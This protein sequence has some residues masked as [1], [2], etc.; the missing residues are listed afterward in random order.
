MKAQSLRREMI[1]DHGHGEVGAVLAAIFLR[2]GKTQMPRLVGTLAHL[3]KQFLP[4]MARQALI[5]PVGAGMFAAMI[6]ETLIVVLRLKRLDFLLDEIVQ[7]G[8]IVGDLLG[9]PEIHEMPPSLPPV[10][11]FAGGDDFRCRCPTL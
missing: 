2:Q 7:N 10:H 1:A 8:E 6:E 4:V 11:S 5:I 3:A 9:N